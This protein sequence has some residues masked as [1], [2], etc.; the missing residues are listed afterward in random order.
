MKIG[1]AGRWFEMFVVSCFE[2]FAW[3]EIAD[4]QPT[5]TG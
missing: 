1:G 3:R 5:A 4:R 2:M